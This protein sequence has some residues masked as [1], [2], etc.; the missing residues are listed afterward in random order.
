MFQLL[1]AGSSACLFTF[2]IEGRW[3]KLPSLADSARA[4]YVGMVDLIAVDLWLLAVFSF[5]HG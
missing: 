2:T 1:A 4:N 5:V 3:V